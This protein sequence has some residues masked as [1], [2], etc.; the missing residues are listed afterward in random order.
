[1]N[2]VLCQRA[3]RGKGNAG[4]AAGHLHNGLP[5]LQRAVGGG[6]GNHMGRQ[7][8]LDAAGEVI[9]LQLG[10]DGLLL[11]VQPVADADHGGVSNQM[12]KVHSTFSSI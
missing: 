11:P 6:F 10:P 8:V 4:V 5:R 12:R 1:M 9:G 2:G 7:P 3:Q